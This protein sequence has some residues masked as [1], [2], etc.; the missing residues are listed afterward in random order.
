LSKEQEEYKESGFVRFLRATEVDTR[1]LGMIF[2]LMM[3][4]L[5]FHLYGHFVNNFGAAIYGTCLYKPLLSRLW[6][7]EWFW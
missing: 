3:I 1:L 6:Q 5:G 4:W 7:P 2:A